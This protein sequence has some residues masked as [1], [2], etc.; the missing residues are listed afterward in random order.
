MS[1]DTSG[2]TL[3][4]EGSPLED[5]PSAEERTVSRDRSDGG[6]GAAPRYGRP[7]GSP[8]GSGRRIGMWGSPSSGK[9]TFLGA[10]RLAALNSNNAYG[11]WQI[12]AA[13]DPSEVFLIESARLLAIARRFPEATQ[14]VSRFSW[15][16]RGD[17]AGSPYAARRWRRESNRAEFELNLMDVS[18]NSYE[19]RHADVNAAESIAH[20][21][22]ADGLVYLFDPTIEALSGESFAYL[23]GTLARLSRMCLAEDRL[24]GPYL[25]H[26]ISVCL[27]K[28]DDPEVFERARRGGWAHDGPHGTPVV[29][30]PE[31]FFDWLTEDLHGGTMR[32]VGEALRSHFRPDRIRFFVTSAIGFGTTPGGTVDLKQ[33][34]NIDDVEG[35]QQII[36]PVRPY[37]VMEPVISLLLDGRRRG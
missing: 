21:A 1:G 16:F 17:L 18:G 35:V 30:N 15:L 4:P 31:G 36:G 14:S 3:F 28:F 20:L 22:G 8:R 29:S 34:G 33:F 6:P 12:I 25:P 2:G 13:D 24:D 23:N 10:L 9:T 27:T 26:R 37:N 11:H 19:D 7:A 32:L 5:P